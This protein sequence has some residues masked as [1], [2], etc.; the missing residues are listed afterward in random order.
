MESFR[1]MSKEELQA[2]DVEVNKKYQETKDHHLSLIMARGK[3]APD[4]GAGVQPPVWQGS[5]GGHSK[6]A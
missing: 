1:E 4:H 2:Q 6:A 5:T 3:P